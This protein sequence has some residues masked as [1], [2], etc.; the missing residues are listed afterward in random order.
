MARTQAERSRAKRIRSKKPHE[1]TRDEAAWLRSYDDGATFVQMPPAEDAHVIEETKRPRPTPTGP[2]DTF[3]PIASDDD[4]DDDEH[5][6]SEA[7]AEP[8]K[9]AIPD[10]PACSGRTSLKPMKCATT[11]EEVWPPLGMSSARG[12][13][14]LVFFCLGW[15]VKVLNKLPE[16]V[17][18]TPIERDELAKAIIDAV[19]RRAGWVAA[20]DDLLAGAWAL[21]AYTKRASRKKELPKEAGSS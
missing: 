4:D 2:P 14:G 1:R 9:C 8:K 13:A 5:A 10:C 6:P 7:L 16:I 15:C 12:L 3:V 17:E 18:P 11:G 19:R 20:F 21:G